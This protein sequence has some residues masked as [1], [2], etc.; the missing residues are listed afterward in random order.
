MTDRERLEVR[1]G[2]EPGFTDLQSVASPLCHRTP[3]RRGG[4][5]FGSAV[6]VKSGLFDIAGPG[7]R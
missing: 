2:I 7:D 3:E 5:W 1:P 6:G 4:I